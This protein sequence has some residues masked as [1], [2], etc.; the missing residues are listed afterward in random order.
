MKVVILNPWKV[1]VAGVISCLLIMGSV[2]GALAIWGV[3]QSDPAEAYG[4][5]GVGAKD[6][7]FAE[8]YTGAGFEEWILI[9]NPPVGIGS[10]NDISPVI[11]MYSNGGSIGTYSVS[12]VAP[13]Q[14]RSININDAAAYYGYSGDVSIR[15]YH[16]D[17][18]FICE[19]A[20]YFNYKDQ[21]TGGSQVFG[22]QEGATE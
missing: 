19:R 9:Y 3:F 17:Y 8:G 4:V 11:E 22:Y 12:K 20:M 15:V 16:P 13:G 1:L 10:G 21:V 6:W 18:P 2:L 5:N 7:Y 14:R